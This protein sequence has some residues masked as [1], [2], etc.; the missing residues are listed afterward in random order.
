M[1][2]ITQKGSVAIVKMVHGKANAMD[3]ALCD[4]LSEHFEKLRSS[5]ARAI[6]LTGQGRIFSAGVD[7]VRAM[8]G[9]PDYFRT[10][11]P[12]LRKMFEAVAFHP[13][14]V[15]ALEIMRFVVAPQYFSEIILGA[16]T[17][18]PDAAAGRGL[19]DEVV[20]PENLLDRA[21]AAAE[22]LAA[23]RPEAFALAKIQCRQ[24]VIAALRAGGPDDAAVDRIWND[25]ASFASI[26]NYVTRT[27]RR[28]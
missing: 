22:S 1:I 25:P 15:I 26:R 13:K 23:L 16:A 6:V 12:S 9:G 11:L 3:L 27:F 14:P 24:P 8:D 18:P 7:L 2:E 20:D 17:Y 5:P 28:A 19:I 10:F 21:V 4:A